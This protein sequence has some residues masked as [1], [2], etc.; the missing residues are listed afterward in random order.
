MSFPSPYSE[1]G[2]GWRLGDVTVQQAQDEVWGD[3]RQGF[4]Q[5]FG[6]GFGMLD[7][8]MFLNGE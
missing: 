7:M 3:S 5:G 6:Q 1:S 2:E 4:V 8:L